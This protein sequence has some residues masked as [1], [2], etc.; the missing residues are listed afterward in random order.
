MESYPQIGGYMAFKIIDNVEEYLS[1]NNKNN[2]KD[3]EYNEFCLSHC[4][5]VLHHSTHNYF[6]VEELYKDSLVVV[7]LMLYADS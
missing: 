6:L 1:T 5:F 3:D 4:F 2:D 7:I